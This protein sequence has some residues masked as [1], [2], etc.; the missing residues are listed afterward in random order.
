M[1]RWP[2]ALDAAAALPIIQA[3]GA[4][5]LGAIFALCYGLGLRA[6]R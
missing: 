6:G 3:A 2:G 1:P 5:L 4:R